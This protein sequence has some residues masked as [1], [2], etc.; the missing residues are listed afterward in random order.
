MIPRTVV[1]SHPKLH[2]VPPAKGSG[3][4]ADK[5]GDGAVALWLLVLPLV[6]GLAG[7]VVWGRPN[8]WSKAAPEALIFAGALLLALYALV[9]AWKDELSDGH[10][11]VAI[12]RAVKLA[13]PAGLVGAVIGATI[14]V[15]HD[16][17]WSFLTLALVLLP[18]VLVGPLSLLLLFLAGKWTARRAAR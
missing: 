8:D 7:G 13:T 18:F 12:E 11:V 10:L 17:D 2:K 14:R 3:P 16:G 6:A 4:L 1:T 15:G 9:S 5:Y